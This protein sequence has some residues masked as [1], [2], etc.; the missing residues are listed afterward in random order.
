MPL[1]WRDAFRVRTDQDKSTPNSTS[2]L[3]LPG[4]DAAARLAR[5]SIET[6]AL[7]FQAITADCEPPRGR[8]KDASEVNMNGRNVEG[9]SI[10]L[11]SAI[12]GLVLCAATMVPLF[13]SPAMAVVGTP[14]TCYPNR[15]RC[16]FCQESETLPS[17][18]SRCLKCVRDPNCR[19][20]FPWRHTRPQDE[21]L[22]R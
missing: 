4:W 14:P 7:F 13:S 9:K 11:A 5:L 2:P 18:R 19:I 12:A 17:G 22:H 15:A 16:I 1:D 21:M 3:L 6:R 20:R 8:V 10:K